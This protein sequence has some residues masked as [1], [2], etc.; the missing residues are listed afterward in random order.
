VTVTGLLATTTPSA[1]TSGAPVKTWSSVTALALALPGD[2]ERQHVLDVAGQ[3]GVLAG[4]LSR[5]RQPDFA[6]A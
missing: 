1:T 4:A 2:V 3:R 5:H 6:A